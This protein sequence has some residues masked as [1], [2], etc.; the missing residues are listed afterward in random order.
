MIDIGHTIGNYRITAKLGEGGMGV[1]YL[2]EH[3]VIGKKVAMK[4]IHPEL[5]KNSDVVSRF[6][7]E[8]KAVNQIGHEHIV[9]IADFGNT[10]DGEFYFVMEY[11]QGESL[12]DRLRRENRLAAGSALSITAQIADAL[13]ASHEQGIIHRDLKPENIFLCVNRGAGRD[14]VK[15]LDF[16]LAKLTLSDQKVS[17][18]TRTG[19][20]MGTP[21]YMSPEQCEG[22][23]EI[24]HRADIYSLGVLLFE[25]LTGK[26]PFGGDGYGEIIV[27]HVTMPPPSVRSLNEE[28]PEEID[29]ILYR[30]LAKDRDQRFQT[31]AELQAALLDPQRYASSAP[32]IGIPDDLSGVA[33][34]ASPMARAEMDAR[35]KIG[36]G[37]GLEVDRAAGG[38][39]STFREGRGEIFERFIPKK[40]NGMLAFYTGILFLAVAVVV[41]F[42]SR[43]GGNK[44][45]LP[46]APVSLHPSAVRI[47]F[48]SDPDG[49]VVLRADGKTL[50]LTP[51]SIEVPYSD[52]A[53][54]FQFR[55]AGFEKKAVY[56]VPNLPSP[57][58]ATLRKI[59]EPPAPQKTGPEP[60]SSRRSS[61]SGGGQPA[62]KKK[63]QPPPTTPAA[64]H[65]DE[66]GTLEPSY[67][68][69]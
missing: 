40:K 6:V 60:T 43:G 44:Q 27:K 14:F 19:S 15:V 66:D 8:A 20:V 46:A 29:L 4:A 13:N 63:K 16:G 35:S 51:L 37:S 34:A 69:P 17:H 3:P 64:T 7:T 21:Y 12:S 45:Q 22:K 48:N 49:A 24:D 31:M 9:D 52:S 41:M 57:L 68:R 1:V 65:D 10:S 33:R 2:A 23:I 18:K 28:L 54:E 25:M 61:S 50:G 36:F 62:E 47:N 26:V 42:T 55:K 5:S 58:F 32:V 39:P 59:E 30:A 56:V 67:G 11:L 53:V 38:I